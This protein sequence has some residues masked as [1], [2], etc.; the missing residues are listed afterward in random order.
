MAE[1]NHIEIEQKWQ[2]HWDEHK[3]FHAEI[4]K[5]KPIAPIA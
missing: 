2:K 5:N 4:D 1:Y 3:T